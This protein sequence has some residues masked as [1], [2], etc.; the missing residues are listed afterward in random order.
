MTEGQP[1]LF[2][3][4]SGLMDCTED[5]GEVGGSG[6][7]SSESSGEL[8]AVVRWGGGATQ[9]TSGPPMNSPAPNKGEQ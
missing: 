4:G 2:G 8:G 3:C 1:C 7:R 9:H 5:D 6:D